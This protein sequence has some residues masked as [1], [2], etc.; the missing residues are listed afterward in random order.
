MFSVDVCKILIILEECIANAAHEDCSQLFDS[1]IMDL[2]LDSELERWID[3]SKE[4]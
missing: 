2:L 4:N 1:E 3:C